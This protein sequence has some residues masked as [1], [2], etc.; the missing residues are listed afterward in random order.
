MTSKRVAKT[1]K[2]NQDDFDPIDRPVIERSPRGYGPRAGEIGSIGKVNG[3]VIE[4]KRPCGH[5][6]RVRFWRVQPETAKIG[7]R[8]LP[9]NGASTQPKT[10]APS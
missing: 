10:L 1:R 3:W 8:R 2:L 7:R 4:S 5:S 9:V 6:F